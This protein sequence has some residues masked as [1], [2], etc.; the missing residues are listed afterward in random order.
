M[1]YLPVA[2]EAAR[3]VSAGVVGLACG[4]INLRLLLGSARRLADGGTSK[5]F[6]LSSL[7]RVGVFAIVAV[8]VAAAGPWWNGLVYIVGLLLPIALYAARAGRER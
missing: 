7:S 3:A 2:A 5:A 4:A 6:V 1:P 8:A